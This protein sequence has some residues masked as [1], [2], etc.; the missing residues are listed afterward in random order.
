MAHNDAAIVVC[1]RH[2]AKL[3]ERSLRLYT[4][5]ARLDDLVRENIVPRLGFARGEA[6]AH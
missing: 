2:L 6:F 4:R 3:L 1:A 5:V